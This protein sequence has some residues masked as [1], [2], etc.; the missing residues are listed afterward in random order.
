M[1][2]HNETYDP[3]YTHPK[4]VPD[5]IPWKDKI[6]KLTVEEMREHS[7]RLEGELESSTISTGCQQSLHIM[8]YNL[9]NLIEIYVGVGPSTHIFYDMMRRRKMVVMGRHKFEEIKN[10]VTK[11]MV[12]SLF[13]LQPEDK[14]RLKIARFNNPNI[15]PHIYLRFLYAYGKIPNNDEVPQYFFKMLIA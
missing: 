8:L 1:Y 11:E 9:N 2:A 6:T 12:F 10:N 13:D 15:T 4:D 5:D 7:M 3:L 14:R